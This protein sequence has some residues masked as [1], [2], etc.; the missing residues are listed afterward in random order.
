MKNKEIT[1]KKAEARALKKREK[2][3]GLL[4]LARLTAVEYF[5]TDAIAYYEQILR[6]DTNHREANLELANVHML[7][8]HYKNAIPYLEKVS[9]LNTQIEYQL[10][11]KMAECYDALN[12]RQRELSIYERLASNFKLSSDLQMRLLRSHCKLGNYKAVFKIYKALKES[13]HTAETHTIMA[14]TVNRISE[15]MVVSDLL[16]AMHL[17]ELLP[18]WCR[19]KRHRDII[20]E[21][22]FVINRRFRKEMMS[23]YF[24]GIL[25]YKEAAALGSM[26]RDFYSR[27][28][29]YLFIGNIKKDFDYLFEKLAPQKNLNMSQDLLNEMLC[30]VIRTLPR[31]KDSLRFMATAGARRQ[32]ALQVMEQTKVHFQGVRIINIPKFL[33]HRTVDGHSLRDVFDTE[34]RLKLNCFERRLGDR[35]AIRLQELDN[36]LSVDRKSRRLP[37]VF[38][39]G[40]LR[41]HLSS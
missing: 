39:T 10:E 14:M 1:K 30:A 8:N 32:R 26:A 7:V 15:L 31:P 16:G 40:Q 27:Y 11:I 13:E 19:Q 18:S 12:E 38:N 29:P 22:Q 6:L 4:V 28:E 23:F 20:Q 25:T 2:I 17:M 21:K 5:S 36:V 34:L 9:R 41:S 24:N 3:A 33:D 37:Q 35:V